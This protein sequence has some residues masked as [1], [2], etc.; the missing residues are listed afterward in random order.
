MTTTTREAVDMVMQINMAPAGQMTA[1]MAP[2][3]MMQSLA[4]KNDKGETLHQSQSSLPM[5]A[6]DF[7]D[8][9]IAALNVVL[10]SVGLVATRAG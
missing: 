6:A 8:A 1:G 7:D 10:A 5:V 3:S 4:I 9:R 2:V